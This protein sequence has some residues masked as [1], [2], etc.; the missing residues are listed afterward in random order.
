M[1]SDRIQPGLNGQ[2]QTL[3]CEHN[4]AGHMDKFSAPSMFGSI[5]RTSIEGIH[6]HMEEGRTSVGFEVNV[7]HLAS[8]NIGKSIIAHAEL[9]EIDRNCL[10]FR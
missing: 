5:E 2:K 6:V 1:A 9:P 3:V 10:L 4:I 7:R 8:A